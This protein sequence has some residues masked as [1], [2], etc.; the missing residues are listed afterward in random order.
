MLIKYIAPAFLGV[1]LLLTVYSCNK[2]DNSARKEDEDIVIDVDSGKFLAFVDSTKWHPAFHSAT[3]YS[4]WNQLYIS[5]SDNNPAYTTNFSLYGGINLDSTTLLKKYLLEPNGDNAFRL[6]Y[7]GSFYSDQNIIDEGGSFTLTKFDTIKKVISG[8]LQF[9]GYDK[10]SP[11]K[12][13]FSSIQ[14]EDIPLNIN[15][16]NYSG[17]NASCTVQGVT[18]TNWQSKNIYAAIDCASL[19][20][21]D[22]VTNETLFIG[23][24]SVF[25]GYPSGRNVF[26][27]VPVTKSKGKYLIYPDVAPYIYCGDKHVVST[28]TD[29]RYNKTYQ[30]VSGELNVI[31][32]DSINRK[33]EATFNILY[34]DTVT[35]ETVNISNGKI[36]L[37]TWIRVGEP[38]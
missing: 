18:T 12:I 33:L 4:K 19:P 28:Y 21:P 2:N 34:R 6:L 24:C 9:N 26:I 23:I 29:G 14:I 37:S 20:A 30:A 31:S 13:V 32:I 8:I 25:K 3:Y 22:S 7:N 17:N 5:A 35:K 11:K 36:N 1:S 27:R 10:Y 16:G 15:S 38:R